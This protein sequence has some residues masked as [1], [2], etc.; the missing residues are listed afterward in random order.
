MLS[1]EIVPNIT[2][3]VT[4]FSNA[5]LGTLLGCYFCVCLMSVLMSLFLSLQ[6]VSVC[7]LEGSVH[8]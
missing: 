6:I 2:L 5:T 8:R 4:V 3:F 1:V 7:H